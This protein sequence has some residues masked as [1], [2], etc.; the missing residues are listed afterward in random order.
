MAHDLLIAISIESVILTVLIVNAYFAVCY[1]QP[2]NN[3]V[4][5]D[6]PKDVVN[7]FDIIAMLQ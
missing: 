6:W 2:E 1:R 7:V 3:D 4:I 5:H